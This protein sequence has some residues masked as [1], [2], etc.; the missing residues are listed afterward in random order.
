MTTGNDIIVSRNVYIIYYREL[1]Y[2]NGK[3]YNVSWRKNDERTIVAISTALGKSAIS[4]VRLAA[5]G[6]FDRRRMFKG[7]D[8][9]TVNS[10]T[11]HYGHI[12]DES[13]II[14]EVLVSVF[15]APRT[16]TREDIVEIGTHGGI[17]VTNR[18][19]ELMLERGCRLAEPGEF[20]NF[21]ERAH[22]FNPSRIGLR[23][24]EAKPRQA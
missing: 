1:V 13:G 5:G 16:Y 14:D 17:Y 7:K 11:V 6:D 9:T 19:L 20:T 18:I 12:F 4:I 2:E 23:I 21:P 8:L 15:R 10:H 3:R 24:I 22:R